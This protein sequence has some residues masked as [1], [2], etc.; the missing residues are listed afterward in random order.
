MFSDYQRLHFFKCALLEFY[1]HLGVSVQF[2][3]SAQIHIKIGRKDGNMAIVK[4]RCYCCVV[5]HTTTKL[6]TP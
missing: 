1:A 4:K 2:Y 3:I 5:V 6:C